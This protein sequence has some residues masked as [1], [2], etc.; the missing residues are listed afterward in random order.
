MKSFSIVTTLAAATLFS[1]GER[2]EAALINLGPGSFTPA[3]TAID[4]STPGTN[5]SHNP[6][7]SFIG[8]PEIGDETVSFGSNFAGQTVIDGSVRTITGT[9][10]GPLT[11]VTGGGN[12]VFITDD[13]APGATSPVL[14]G[15]PTFNGPISIFFSNPVA[16]VG[17]KG[18]FFDAIGATTIEAFDD[19]G[20]SLGS[21]TNSSLGFEFYGLFD[22][23]GNNI[24]GL[25]FYITGRESAGFAID[26]VM[27][28]SASVVLVP[29]PETYAMM[30]AGLGLLGFM[31][32]RRKQIA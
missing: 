10:S 28:G 8:L 31:A 9:P 14:S 1:M 25:S 29:E 17:L 19:S 20:A 24:S 21:I 5:G 16:A 15:T 2:V 27:F 13:S 6:I 26:D 23:T 30:L 22:N 32:R 12:D 4:F 3:A 11:L 18:G 7:Y